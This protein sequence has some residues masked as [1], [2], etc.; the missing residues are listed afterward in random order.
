MPEISA[1]G[2][3]GL[4]KK[5]PVPAQSVKPRMVKAN[6]TAT[7]SIKKQTARTPGIQ[8]PKSEAAEKILSAAFELLCLRGYVA[9][10]M[11]DIAQGAGV[12]LSQVAYHFGSK[13]GL[14]LAVIDQMSQ[15]Y[16]KSAEEA[17]ATREPGDKMAALTAFFKWLIKEKP[18]LFRLLIDFSAQALWIPS[19][20][21]RLASLFERMSKLIQS[22]LPL[23]QPNCRFKGYPPEY[24]ARF[25]LGAL[26]GTTLQIVLNGYPETI[27]ENLNLAETL[28]G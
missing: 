9:V 3:P 6:V 27:L 5:Q 14:F 16:L 8:E 15:R 24:I 18:Q 21:E 22:H 11:R 28:L 2:M 26:Y 1:K 25:I 4:E 12:A 19:F 13:E 7:R 17:L 20:G 23:D 10:S